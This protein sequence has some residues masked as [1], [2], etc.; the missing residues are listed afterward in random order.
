[1]DIIYFVQLSNIQFIH[2]QQ[3]VNVFAQNFMLQIYE[4]FIKIYYYY[5]YYYCEI[6]AYIFFLLQKKIN[7]IKTLINPD[8]CLKGPC[9]YDKAV[10]F[11]GT[12]QAVY[13]SYIQYLKVPN[14]KLVN[15]A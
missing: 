5:Y 9:T 11:Y 12:H 1:M 15:T 8:L 14:K 6:G 10:S 4:F 7:D 13:T 3:L 2:Q